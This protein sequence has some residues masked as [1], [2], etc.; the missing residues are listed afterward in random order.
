[1]E[2]SNKCKCKTTQATRTTITVL[3]EIAERIK[4]HAKLEKKSINLILSEK[5]PPVEYKKKDVIDEAEN[6]LN[7]V[8]GGY[9]TK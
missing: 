1:M 6:I 2:S 5:F 9:R 3:K 7:F 8:M 4:L